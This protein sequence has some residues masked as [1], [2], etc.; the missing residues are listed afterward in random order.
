MK[1]MDIFLLNIQVI[2]PPGILTKFP[3]DIFTSLDIAQYIGKSGKYLL[4]AT[5]PTKI[6]IVIIIII[7]CSNSL[8]A[9]AAVIYP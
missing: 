8:V 6:T 9:S 2:F 4:Q 3:V 1:K 5:W 7:D